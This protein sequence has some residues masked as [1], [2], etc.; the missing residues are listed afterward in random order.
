MRTGR[1]CS[2]YRAEAYGE[3]RDQS[4]EVALRHSAQQRNQLVTSNHAISFRIHSQPDSDNTEIISPKYNKDYHPSPPDGLVYSEDTAAWFFFKDYVLSEVTISRP[5]F[6]ELPGLYNN[7]PDGSA[8]SCILS[9]LGL[10]SL[11]ISMQRPEV[12][13][14]AHAKYAQALTAVNAALRNPIL[15]KDD[16]TLLVVMLLGLYEEVSAYDFM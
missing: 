9:A 16:H 6:N 3:F 15:A 14:K 11:S 12:I 1:I 13:P 5:I 4:K 8:L 10:A 7:A 2:G